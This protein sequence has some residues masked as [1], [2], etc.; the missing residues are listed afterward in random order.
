MNAAVKRAKRCESQPSASA[1]SPGHDWELN[2]LSDYARRQFAE[3]RRREGTLAPYYWRLGNALSLARK[4]FAHG[5]WEAYLAEL[6]IDK[7]RASKAMA[8]YGT[9][10]TAEAVAKLT[11]DEAY[12]ARRSAHAAKSAEE[13]AAERPV[14]FGAALGRIEK[15]GTQILVDADHWSPAEREELLG[16]LKHAVQCL[17]EQIR[18]LQALTDAEGEAQA[19]ARVAPTK[20]S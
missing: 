19:S 16:R 11:V 6:E 10:A 20:L 8:I 17:Q 18:R 7:S 5:Q 3:I 4:N 12:E 14:K 9:F 13:A 1:A 15:T 2:R